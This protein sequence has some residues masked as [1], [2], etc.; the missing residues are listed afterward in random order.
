MIELKNL[1]TIIQ[2]GLNALGSNVFKVF[3]DMGEFQNYYKAD[4]SNDITKY[5]NGILEVLSPSILPIKN[6]QVLTWSTR[7]TFVLDADMLNKDDDGNFLEV[8][9]IRAV[10]QKY[11]ANNNG[12][13]FSYTDEDDVIFEITPSFSGV[14]VGVASQLSP[15]GNALPMY[16]DLSYIMVESGVNSNAVEILLNSENLYFETCSITRIRTADT[17]IF[18]ADNTT[19][20]LVL[21]NGISIGLNLP[22]L[23]TEQGLIMEQDVLVGGNNQAQ[24]VQYKRNN[25][26]KNYI[27][28]F[29]DN[30]E[31]FSIGKNIGMSIKLAE[32]RPDL[33]TYGDNWTKTNITVSAN[34][35]KTVQVQPSGVVFWGDG[36]SEINSSSVQVSKTHTYT[37]AGTY[38]L[39]IYRDANYKFDLT[40][41]ATNSGVTLDNA[42]YY[43]FESQSGVLSYNDSVVIYAEGNTDYSLDTFTVT[44]GGVSQTTSITNG[45]GT[46]T[47]ASV[48]GDIVVTAISTQNE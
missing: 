2:D 7:V 6:L 18:S 20:Q 35:T 46:C 8:T 3:A 48:I 39:L 40:I 43:Y 22:L 9:E 13:P 36:E 24:L 4:N 28:V 23:N 45:L 30:T 41:N 12:V 32:G 26:T 47:I 11:M 29:G 25:V 14:S 21:T 38:T 19:K 33:L 34:E 5:V 16:L 31:S 44:M 42:G 15:L 37:N 17:N 1:A 10:L 27:M